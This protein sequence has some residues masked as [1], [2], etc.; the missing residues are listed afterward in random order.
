MGSGV[1]HDVNVQTAQL[2]ENSKYDA[3]GRLIVRLLHKKPNMGTRTSCLYATGNH[4][5]RLYLQNCTEEALK[6]CCG[7]LGPMMAKL[8]ATDT[9]V[10]NIMFCK[11]LCQKKLRRLDEAER[12]LNELKMLFHSVGSARNEAIIAIELVRVL[13]LQ[14]R[15]EDAAAIGEK[16]YKTCRTFFGNDDAATRQAFEV[17]TNVLQ[18]AADVLDLYGLPHEAQIF[19][20][21]IE[22]LTAMNCST[23]SSNDNSKM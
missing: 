1:S 4:A 6:V 17:I 12:T 9:D 7:L 21:R 14:K 18:A 10:L 13:V 11:A 23:I 22:N 15:Y 2:L 5:M 16:T 8:G 3:A 20:K 19:V